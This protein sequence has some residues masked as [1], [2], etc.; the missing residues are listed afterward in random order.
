MKP[1][2]RLISAA[3]LGCLFVS[4][5]AG[6]VYEIVWARYLALFLGHTSYAVMMVLVAFMG[7]LA[8]GSFW[9]GRRADRSREPLALYAWLEVGIG[10]FGL[11]F[12]WYYAACHW[13]FVALARGAQPGPAGLL[14]LKFVFSLLA[15]FLPTVLMGGTLP[16]LAKC[17]IRSL[18][19][20]R[21][22]VA[23]LYAT[24]SAGG[25]AG[26]LVADFWLIP[27]VGLQATVFSAAIL[28]LAAGAVAL[29]L[30]RRL[31]VEPWPGNREAPAPAV[32][33][34]FSPSELR[35]AVIGIGVSGFVA[36]L[37][38]VAWTRLLALVMGSSTHA[39]SVM[40]MTFIA[41]LATGAWA[42]ARWKTL[43]RTLVAFA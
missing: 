26:C 14:A 41:G 37:Y 31:R 34:Q 5:V 18:S 27:T 40:L 8:L 1:H 19:E 24:N 28:N 36:M 23:A 6:L 42:I 21:G 30:N 11:V 43:R 15:I 2:P 25:V 38:E 32:A 12:P 13:A 16:A 7:G 35:L 29:S 9:L 4:G 3:L 39:F 10:V 22:K 20:L 33:E 17:V